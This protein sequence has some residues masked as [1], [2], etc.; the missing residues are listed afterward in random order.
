MSVITVLKVFKNSS[1]IT[2]RGEFKID[3]V[4]PT[5]KAANKARYFYYCSDCGVEIY[6]KRPKPH[7]SRT[8]NS[9]FAAVGK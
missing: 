5:G 7:H 4:F 8:G 2:S 1:L 6:S 3:R 9:K